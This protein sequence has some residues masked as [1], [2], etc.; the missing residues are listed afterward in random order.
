M[1]GVQVLKI[2][3]GQRRQLNCL[4]TTH[5]IVDYENKSMA[6]GRKND[7]TLLETN[8]LLCKDFYEEDFFL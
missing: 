2:Q 5:Y 7:V 4:W 3:F 6:R 1:E 8:N